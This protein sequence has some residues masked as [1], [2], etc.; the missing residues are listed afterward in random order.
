MPA[1]FRRHDLGGEMMRFV[2]LIFPSLMVILAGCGD[3]GPQPP[4]VAELTAMLQSGDQKV[5]I[6]AANWVKQLGPR[7][8]ETRQSLA[9]ALKSPHMSVRHHAALTLAHI[10]PEAAAAV[11]ALTA[12]LNDQ[13]CTVR[14]AAAET[15]GQI[16]PAAATAVPE[17]EKLSRR[18]DPCNAAPAALKKIRQ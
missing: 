16:G 4:S 10:G 14:Q 18:P 8:A 3:K 2:S 7:A 5:Q 1:K 12:A 15:L 11:P 17:L 6:E 9:A 13:E